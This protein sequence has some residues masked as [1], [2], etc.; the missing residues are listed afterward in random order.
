MDFFKK[1]YIIRGNVTTYF[2][3]EQNFKLSVSECLIKYFFLYSKDFV[4]VP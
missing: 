1:L 2:G 3:I 4:L